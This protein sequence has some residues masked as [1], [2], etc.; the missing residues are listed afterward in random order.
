ML[1]LRDKFLVVLSYISQDSWLK[2]NEMNSGYFKKKR[3]I[4]RRLEGLM[5]P[6]GVQTPRLG[7]AG[8]NQRKN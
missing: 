4:P 8:R 5:E 6:M 7:K 1:W 3:K 2:A